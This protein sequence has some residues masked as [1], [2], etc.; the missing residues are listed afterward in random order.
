MCEGGY[1]RHT[2]GIPPPNGGLGENILALP[3]LPH[4]P[5][6]NQT[7]FSLIFSL[8]LSPPQSNRPLVSIFLEVENGLDSSSHVLGEREREFWLNNGVYVY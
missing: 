2:H 8:L 5:F 4:L 1:M 7:H 6:L 3:F